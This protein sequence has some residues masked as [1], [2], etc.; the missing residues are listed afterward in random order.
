MGRRERAIDPEADPVRQLAAGLRELR[1]T[2]GTPPYRELAARAHYSASALSQAANGKRLP[3]LPVFLAFVTA[4]GGDEATWSTRW[5]E[6]AAQIGAEVN[7]AGTSVQEPLE[8]SPPEASRP[9]RRR[10]RYIAW[11]GSAVLITG[12]I[13]VFWATQHKTAQPGPTVIPSR[14]GEGQVVDLPSQPAVDGADPKNSG[15]AADGITIDSARIIYPDDRLAGTIELRYSPHCAAGWGR[16]V[17]APTGRGPDDTV[18]I[19]ISRP[20]DRIRLPY[21]ISYGDQAAYGDI[22]HTAPGCIIAS[23]SVVSGGTRSPE[24]ATACLSGP[25]GVGSGS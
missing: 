4:C 8:P 14:S 3:T 1:R 25:T 18:T 21:T 6:T 23:A 19:A 15:C 9:T 10:P 5:H 2:A 11:V 22:L 12:V 13:G 24:V 17:P 20:A 16:F 7:P